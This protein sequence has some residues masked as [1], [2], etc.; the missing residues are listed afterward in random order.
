MTSPSPPVILASASATRRRLLEAAGVALTAVPARIDEEEIKASMAADGASAGDIAEALAELKARRVSRGHPEALVIGADQV[1]EHDGVL[2]SKPADRNAA[3]SQLIALRGGRHRLIDCVCVLRN[4]ERLWHHSD[5]ARLDMRDFSD[6]F[7][8]A[9]LEQVGDQAFEGPGA[10]RLEGLGAQ[11]FA[12]IDGDYFTI[13]GLPLLPL[14][15]Y[16]RV[17][18][19]VAT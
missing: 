9:Y 12:R 7:L 16:L 15:D 18:G 11:L 13:L 4:G 19:V 14:L 6:A 5:A 17:Q 10:Y 2:Y 1:L 8:D 3:R